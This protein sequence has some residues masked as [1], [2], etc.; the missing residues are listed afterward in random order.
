MGP[1]RTIGTRLSLVC[2]LAWVLGSLVAGPARAAGA[3]VVS[4]EFDNDTISE[5]TLAWQQA[6]QPHGAKATFFVKSGTV[7]SSGNFM[8]RS[9]IGTLAGAGNDIGGK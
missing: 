6:L 1:P 8:S 2:V 9:Q 7:G 5:Y 3:T 4:L